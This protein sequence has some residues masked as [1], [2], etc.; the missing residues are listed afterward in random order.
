MSIF[1]FK[2]RLLADGGVL[3]D[4]GGG[5]S[6][7]SSGPSQSTVYNT[8]IPEYAQPYVSNMLN[9]A[10]AQIYN[11][12]M[13]GFNPY[14]PYS[15][16][17]SNYVAGFSPLQQQAQSGAANLR[18]PGQYNY[19]TNLAGT[20]GAGALG[21][22]GGAGMYGG[23]GAQAGAQSA[24]LSNMFGGLGA[25]AGQQ[26]AG[27]SSMYGNQG[28]N[29]GNQAAGQSTMY[30]GQGANIGQQYGGMSA[31]TGAGAQQAGQQAAGV[32]N[33]YGGL[34]AMQGQ[35]GA[36]I[37]SSLGRMSTD[38]GA[39][40]AYMNPYL[41]SS[42]NPQLQLANQ[43]YGLAGQQQQGAATSAGAFG[44][45][46]S[47]LA[48]SLNQQN[49]MLAQNQI[50]GQGYNTAFN[51]AQQQMNAANQAALSGNAQALQGYGMGLQGAG[52]AGSQALQGYGLNLQ[53][54]NQAGQLG[55]A[56]TAQGLQGAQQAGQL[57]LAGNAQALQGTQQAAQQAFQ[58]Y[59]MGLQGAQQAGQLGIAGA[60]TGLQGIGAQQ[61]GYGLANTAAGNLAN[62]GGQQLAAQ[63]GIIG[64]Q[65]QQGGMQQA[66]QQ[67]IINQAIQNYATAQQYPMLQL[68]MLN[69]MLRGLPMQSAT[70]SMYQAQPT[71]TQQAIGLG[72]TAAALGAAYR[73]EGGVIKEKRMAKGGIADAIPGFKYGAVINDAQLE[74]KAQILGAQQAQPGQP[75]PLQQRI[76]DPQVTPNE[77]MMFQGVETD[78]NRLR[79]NPGAAQMLQQAAQ[80]PQP[81]Q[82]DPRM[83][84]QARM[85]GLGAAGGSAFNAQGFAGGGIIAFADEGLVPPPKTIAN[86]ATPEEFAAARQA[87]MT[88]RGF[89]VGPSPEEQ[90]ALEEYKG[91]GSDKTLKRQLALAAAKG[92]A[93][94]GTTA[95]PGGLGQALLMGVNEALP[96]IAGA[97]DA[98]ETAQR[99]GTKAAA[100][101]KMAQRKFAAGDT[102]EAFKDYDSYMKNKTSEKVANIHAATSGK[103]A[104]SEKA[105][106]DQLI[107]QGYKLPEALQIVKG[108]GRSESVESSN[109]KILLKDINDQIFNLDPKKDSAKIAELEKQ[110]ATIVANLQK[111]PGAGGPQAPQAGSPDAG[112]IVDIPGKGK[113]KQL[114]NGN[115]VKV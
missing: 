12:S 22:V 17:P 51:N 63:Q 99:S 107:A 68:G 88:K 108:A 14:I 69:S 31:Q 97:Y 2:R 73:K 66:Q 75:S 11:P 95:A 93:K 112:G 65:T 74:K 85:S 81:Q 33:M 52:Q 96:G 37:G 89:D 46:R 16:D 94:V 27:Q 20:A 39:V 24:E 98:Q 70:T 38:P 48:N 13:T 36:A 42:L 109:A 86:P 113:F 23:M 19:A 71:G 87:M 53:G 6:G 106:V 115:F 104:A 35:Q 90:T 56:G 9:A 60:Q 28:S 44:G 67:Q 61:A 40:N 3:R 83:M 84:D 45:S 101:L 114:P 34:G 26:Y 78:Q 102:D 25:Q 77:R 64:T 1:N 49:Q 10:Q 105:Y 79:Q 82:M 80:P 4:S 8:N 59:G 41:Q 5:S 43:Q 54:L 50:I 111:G 91:Y 30:G 58:G 62:I 21:T 18:M 92:F 55:L 57:G 7:G 100:D 32:S 76:D 72:G 15:N 47:A 103:Q 110:R 29:I